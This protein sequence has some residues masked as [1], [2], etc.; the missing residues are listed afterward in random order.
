[1]K[2]I[3]LPLILDVLFYTACAFGERMFDHR[4]RRGGRGVS[5]HL[6]KTQKAGAH[7]S[8]TKQKG[9]THA[10]PHPRTAEPGA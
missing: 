3:D 5:S 4:A 7:Q 1:M 2:K 8:G 9:K 6:F 10:A